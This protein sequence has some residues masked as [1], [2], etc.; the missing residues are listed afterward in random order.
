MKQQNDHRKPILATLIAT[1]VLGCTAFF[2]NCAA[3]KFSNLPTNGSAASL[4]APGSL[5]DIDNNPMQQNIKIVLSTTRDGIAQ[6]TFSVN[7]VIHGKVT[8]LGSTNIAAC[9]EIVGVSAACTNDKF[10]NMPANGW[11]FDGT[12]WRTSLT[13]TADYANKNFRSYWLDKAT[14]HKSPAYE[15]KVVPATS[16]ALACNWEGGGAV[17]GPC[18][19]H[20]TNCSQSTVNTT[21]TVQCGNGAITQICVCK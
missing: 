1:V 10:T 17:I 4:G 20:T 14:G 11:T 13:A 5:P 3:N 15:F 18:S 21:A 7:Q 6:N 12:A 9:V 8:G 2:Q 19:A 16:I